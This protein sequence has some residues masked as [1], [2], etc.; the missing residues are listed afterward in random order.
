MSASPQQQMANLNAILRWTIEHGH[1]EDAPPGTPS[2]AQAMSDERR[3]WL[4]KALVTMVDTTDVIDV[5]AKRLQGMGPTN[6]LTTLGPDGAVLLTPSGETV[7]AGA[8][9]V[10][11]VVDTTGAG[12]CFRAAFTVALLKGAQPAECLHSAAAAAAV[13]IQRKGAMPSMPSVGDVEAISS[14]AHV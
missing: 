1:K 14:K 9:K 13:C 2:Y 10:V 11:S 6:V 8:P 5:V 12:D 3:A 4:Q 7:R